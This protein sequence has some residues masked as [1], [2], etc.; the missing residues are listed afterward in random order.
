MK[1]VIKLTEN[2]LIKV[3]KQVISEQNVQSAA[4]KAGFQAGKAVKQTVIKIGQ[5]SLTIIFLPA[6]VGIKLGQATFKVAQAI[7]N[8]I[9]SFLTALAK[10]VKGIVIGAAQTIKYTANQISSFIS[11]A[12]TNILQFFKSM[13]DAIWKLGQAAWGAAVIA[14]SKIAELWSYV[15]QFAGNMLNKAYNFVKGG[16]QAVGQGIKKGAQAVGSAIQSGAQAVGKGLSNAWDAASGFVSGLFESILEDYYYYR[17][18]STRR[19]MY[20]AHIDTREVI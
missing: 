16:V 5:I 10:Q 19:L 15:K 9:L 3:I 11:K 1:K 14:A 4:F 12:S 7:G 13:F 20:E 18:L 17:S 8:V 6:I 2:D